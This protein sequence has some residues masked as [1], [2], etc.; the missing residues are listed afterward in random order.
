MTRLSDAE[1]HYIE[2]DLSDGNVID[3]GD[4]QRLLAE[5]VERRRDEK[6]KEV[7]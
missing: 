2:H 3:N 6:T 5:V 7:R 4:V 1:L